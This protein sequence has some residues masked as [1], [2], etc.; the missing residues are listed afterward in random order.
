MLHLRNVSEHRSPWAQRFRKLVRTPA[1]GRSTVNR[2]DWTDVQLR[3]IRDRF[4]KY[5]RRTNCLCQA[6]NSTIIY[7]QLG[8]SPSSASIIPA[9]RKKNSKYLRRCFRDINR[10]CSECFSPMSKCDSVSDGDEPHERSAI[11]DG[12][13]VLWSWTAKQRPIRRVGRHSAGNTALF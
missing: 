9:T 10:E 11:R 5:S 4:R 8:C 2:P 13:K 6:T 7:S 3:L 12:K 1:I